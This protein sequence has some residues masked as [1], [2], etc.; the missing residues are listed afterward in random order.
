VIEPGARFAARPPFPRPGGKIP[1]MDLE[2]KG[3]S[4]MVAAASKGIGRAVATSLAREGCRVSICSRSPES[5]E[6]ARAAI[7][8]E[9]P[10]A[11]LH[12]VPCDLAKAADLEA[13]FRA[14]EKGFGGVDILVTNAGG[15]PAARFEELTEEQWRAGI[16]G[17]LM[18]VVRLSRLVLPGMRARRWGRIVHLTS[19]VARQPAELLTVSSTL[20]AG[21]SALTK[22]MANQAAGD[23]VLVNAVLP[24]YVATDRQ[25][26]LN[27]IRAKQAGVSIEEYSARA[28]DAIPLK[29]SAR[30]QELG[31]VVAFLCSERASY[32]SGVSLLVDGSL[33]QGTF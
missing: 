10:G 6:S 16:D 5:L 28:S 25:I 3:R 30:P 33:V 26:E 20:R 23:N 2:L 29:R 32:V 27:G 19:F 14:A 18:N 7:L 4:A 24:G 11:D 9:A 31:D 22:T 12:S 8:R 1:A 13:W 15:P 21:I 17:T